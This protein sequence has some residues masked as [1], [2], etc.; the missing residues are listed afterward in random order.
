MIRYGAR[1]LAFVVFIGTVLIGPV[2]IGSAANPLAAK[3]ETFTDPNKAGP[4]YAVQG[5][6]RG[7]LRLDG[8]ETPI[9]V[10]VIALGNGKFEAVIYRGGLPGEGWS[11][12]DKRERVPGT[13][14]DSGATFAG[15]N[16]KAKIQGSKMTFEDANGADLGRLARASRRSPTLGARPPSRAL[17]LFNGKNVDEFPGAKV[18]PDGLLMPPATSKRRFGDFRLHIEFRTPFMPTARGQDRGNSGVYLQNRYEVQVLDSFGLE[19]ANNECGGIYSLREP[20]V[21]M[22]YPPLAWQTY[23]IYFTGPRFEANKKVSDPR[24]T[25]EHNGVKIYKDFAIPKL[26][27]GG[28]TKERAG[29]GPLFLQFHG[30]PVT[31]RNIWIVQQDG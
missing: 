8:R 3:H 5:E 14:Q 30:N 21:N 13:R 2:L 16:W 4:D 31:Y 15:P 25:I 20:A 6:F 7:N 12:G 17:M 22:C 27:P 24:V 9:G 18:T 10:Q 28:D 1:P 26:T 23:D 19:G 11:R 29:G